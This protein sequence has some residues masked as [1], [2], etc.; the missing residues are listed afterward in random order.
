MNNSIS[1]ETHFNEK[2]T[3]GQDNEEEVYGKKIEY[4]FISELDMLSSLSMKA[5][6]DLDRAIK[7]SD[8]CGIWYSIHMLLFTYGGI[9]RLLSQI[10]KLSEKNPNSPKVQDLKSFNEIYSKLSI[11]QDELMENFGKNLE[12]WIVDPRNNRI[13][14]NYIFE[15]SAVPSMDVTQMLRHF[16]P[17]TYELT[18]R[19]KTYDLKQDQQEVQ[20][21]KQNVEDLYMKNI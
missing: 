6:E 9:S 10:I 11:K 20:K 4:A 13:M 15:R 2:E 17:E 16:D 5:F 18:F 19:N 7:R 8:E 14:D 1:L 12:G 21:I 3:Y